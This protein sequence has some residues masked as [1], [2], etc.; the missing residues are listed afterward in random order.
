LKA[1]AS[2][3]SRNE[4]GVW[5]KRLWRPHDTFLEFFRVIWILGVTALYYAFRVTESIVAN[6]CKHFCNIKVV[7]CWNS[8]SQISAL[9]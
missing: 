8:L 4:L 9:L 7:L 6:V 3:K 1:V 2:R 5:L